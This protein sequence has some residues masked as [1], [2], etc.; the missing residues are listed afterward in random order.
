MLRLR[1]KLVLC[2]LS[3]AIWLG[4]PGASQASQRTAALVR[5]DTPP[6]IDGIL[7]EPVWREAVLLEELIQTLPT[8]GAP[9]TERTEMR[10]LYDRD[11]L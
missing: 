1:L 9:P 2:L 11:F 10:L 3:S 4:F 7:D 6:V 5:T 8:E